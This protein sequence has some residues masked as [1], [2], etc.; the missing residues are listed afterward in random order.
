MF[1]KPVIT[2][3]QICYLFG[4]VVRVLN[5]ETKVRD[6]NPNVHENYNREELC[7]VQ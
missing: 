5:T 6:S 2:D 7:T 4:A 3:I 1:I